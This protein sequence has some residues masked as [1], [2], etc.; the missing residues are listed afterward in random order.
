M[1][2]C[3]H[4]EIEKLQAWKTNSGQFFCSEFCADIEELVT[5]AEP[6]EQGRKLQ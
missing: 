5:I 3:C 6:P 2:T 4:E 1:I